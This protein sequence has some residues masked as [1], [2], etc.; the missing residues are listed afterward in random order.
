MEQKKYEKLGVHEHLR[1]T[2]SPRYC[3]DDLYFPGRSVL[4]NEENYLYQ[5]REHAPLDDSDYVTVYRAPDGPDDARELSDTFYFTPDGGKSPLLAG[6]HVHHNG[7]EFFMIGGENARCLIQ[8]RGRQSFAYPG[9]IVFLP[10]YTP[11]C[12]HWYGSPLRWREMFSGMKMNSG[13][14]RD[15]RILRFDG[16]AHDKPD[17]ESLYRAQSDYHTMDFEPD[18]KDVDEMPEIIRFDKGHAAFDLGGARFL[19]KI[20]RAQWWGQREIWQMHLPAGLS[21]HCTHRNDKELLLMVYSGRVKVEIDG[22]EPFIA[23][24]WDYLD[25]PAWL[26]AKVTVQEDAVL[27]D[28]DCRGTLADA[29]EEIN[30]RAAKDAA[31][32]SDEQAQREILERNGIYAW[33]SRE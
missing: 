10:P 32:L 21:L 24:Q 25:I 27:F 30:A 6:Y 18:F 3:P 16:E 17:F 5:I 4:L 11:H 26:G 13:M 14:C 1:S 8:S 33:I 29:M 2:F 12:F 7:F 28:C 22:V 19:Q 15:W 20:T 31:L 23:K 9:D